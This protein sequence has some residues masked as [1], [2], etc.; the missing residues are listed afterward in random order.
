MEVTGLGA[1]HMDKFGGMYRLSYKPMNDRPTYKHE[2]KELYLY[3]AASEGGQWLIGEKLSVMTTSMLKGANTSASTPDKVGSSWAVRDGRKWVDAKALSVVSHAHVE[4][5]VD[6]RRLQVFDAKAGAMSAARAAQVAAHA[7][8]AL[9]VL[10]HNTRWW[11]KPGDLVAVG[12]GEYVPGKGYADYAYGKVEEA[13]GMLGTTCKVSFGGTWE[14]RRGDVI[15]VL[16]GKHMGKCAQV[17][18]TSQNSAGS[19]DVKWVHGHE[20]ADTTIKPTPASIGTA[21]SSKELKI[22]DGGCGD[23]DGEH[24]VQYRDAVLG[25]KEVQVTQLTAFHS[26]DA[27]PYSARA[28]SAAANA[29]AT[30]GHQLAHILALVWQQQAPYTAHAAAVATIASLE[31]AVSAAT[32]RKAWEGAWAVAINDGAHQKV[33]KLSDGPMIRWQRQRLELCGANLA[34]TGSRGSEPICAA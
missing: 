24:Q 30:V 27:A 33:L 12:I 17:L 11:P 1:T 28:A 18:L 19:F 21:A 15:K 13:I 5:A 7:I 8:E 23:K 10:R 32:A 4:R 6:V 9:S 25:V 14:T 26:D 29:A 31:A 16:S 20:E 3:H 2:D 34:L 22:R